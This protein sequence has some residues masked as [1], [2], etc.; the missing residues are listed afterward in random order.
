MNLLT[1]TLILLFHASLSLQSPEKTF[2]QYCLEISQHDTRTIPQ[3]LLD[4]CAFHTLAFRNLSYAILANLSYTDGP[5][6]PP[7]QMSL[8]QY[9]QIAMALYETPTPHLL[10]FGCGLDT[11]AFVNLVKYLNGSAVFIEGNRKVKY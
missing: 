7:E 11:S 5:R 8:E 1:F 10:Y 2:E 6:R 3:I 9:L 4:I